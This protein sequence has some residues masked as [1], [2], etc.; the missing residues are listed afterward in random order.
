M[1][2][3]RSVGRRRVLGLLVA[4]LT[5]MALAAPALAGTGGFRAVILE[6][7]GRRA[8]AQPCWEEAAG[9]ACA[10]RGTVQGYGSVTSKIL[11]PNDPAEPL[12]RTL[13]FTD[14]STLVLEETWLDG[15]GPGRAASA[16]GT[17]VSFGNPWFDRY[18]WSVV[19]G[20]GTF[21]EATGAGTWENVLAGDTIVIRFSG[22]LAVP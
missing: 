2:T 6:D 1:T 5:A 7:F 9:F 12:E 20:S 8:S 4:A 13:T 14:G 11:F 17:I 10:G 3:F 16:P 18:A 15:A 22:T 19:G 21:A